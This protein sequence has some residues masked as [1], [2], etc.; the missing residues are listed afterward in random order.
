R[1]RALSFVAPASH[2][3]A[4]SSVDPNAPPYGVRLR[5]KASFDESRVAS[6][7][8]KIIVRALKKYGM[9]LADGG[10]IPLTAEK[11]D[12]S[13]LKYGSDLGSHDLRAIEPTDFDVVELGQVQTFAKRP[14]CTLGL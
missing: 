5:L 11:D 6:A 13:T 12:L 14:D 10:N 3:G 1:M 7:G 9:I 2:F 4:P 8:G